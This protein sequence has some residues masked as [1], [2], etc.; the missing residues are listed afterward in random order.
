MPSRKLNAS[1]TE[2]RVVSV[3]P[4]A[5]G[6]HALKTMEN[7]KGDKIMSVVNI[8]TL[9]D[10]NNKKKTYIASGSRRNG[11]INTISRG[12]R[13]IQSKDGVQYRQ[14]K[15]IV[16]SAH[17]ATT[18]HHVVYTKTPNATIYRNAEESNMLA[19][20]TRYVSRNSSSLIDFVKETKAIDNNNVSIQRDKTFDAKVMKKESQITHINQ[21][22]T[23]Q[24]K[25]KASEHTGSVYH[26]TAQSD[27]TVAY[28]HHEPLDTKIGNQ[29]SINELTV[30]TDY[31]SNEIIKSDNYDNATRHIA[32]VTAKE[33]L[34]DR[35]N[36]VDY[37]SKIETDITE[38]NSRLNRQSAKLNR[39]DLC[40]NCKETVYPKDKVGPIRNVMFH[41]QCFRCFQCGYVLNLYNYY[42]NNKNMDDESVYCKSHQPAPES[43]KG[44]ITDKNIQ[45]LINK[46]KLGRVNS[47]VRGEPDAKL[48]IGTDAIGIKNAINA[49]KLGTYNPTVRVTHESGSIDRIDH[50]AVFV[51][52]AM[53]AP[54]LDV[55][56]QTVRPVPAMAS[57]PNILRRQQAID[58]KDRESV[59]VQHGTRPVVH[60]LYLH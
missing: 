38:T 16:Y 34:E 53:K 55:Y 39:K 51:Q 26:N 36:V 58:V 44:D 21:T 28:P 11:H 4:T 23:H 49:P 24:I 60:S 25:A 43:S 2:Y 30:V 18:A 22:E 13:I 41:T 9:N 5:D 54:K 42:Q 56:N 40:F 45:S 15:A 10:A 48:R 6:K 37:E 7:N 12:N 32:E 59:H 19:Y 3:L 50:K 17:P 47:N 29:N 31:N 46:P 8:E 1:M 57:S 35:N 20:K 14:A 27:T 33:L 52:T